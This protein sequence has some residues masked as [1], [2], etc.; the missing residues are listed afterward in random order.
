MGVSE[1]SIEMLERFKMLSKQLFNRNTKIFKNK[2]GYYEAKIYV[3]QLLSLF[4]GLDLNFSG[5]SAPPDWITETS[6]FGAY[7]A[8][9]IDGDGNI[10]IHRPKY[11][12]CIIRITSGRPSTELM[13]LIKQTLG[14][15][16]S[17]S[18]RQNTSYLNGRKISG[19]GYILQFCVSKKNIEEL[20]TYVLPWISIR[21]KRHKLSK[22][23]SY[24]K[25]KYPHK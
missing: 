3:N 21:H 12:Q 11:P 8:G 25:S 6:L 15:A 17:I 14:C 16:A 2:R 22:F 9:I 19:I 24:F 1:K 18:S 10:H 23:I 5:L 4:E 13:L 7:L 20:E